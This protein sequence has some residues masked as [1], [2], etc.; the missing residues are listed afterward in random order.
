MNL[1]VTFLVLISLTI[2]SGRQ[3]SFASNDT[4]PGI[5]V[6]LRIE[7]ANY[8]I[9]EGLVLSDNHTISTPSSN[10]TF[11]CDGTNNHTHLNSGPTFTS[12][13]DN[14]S[15]LHNFTWD[16]TYSTEFDDFFITSIGNK[17]QGY[18]G[19]LLNY[20]FIIVGGCQQRVRYMD[21]VLFGIDAFNKVHI[22]MLDGPDTAIVGHSTQLTVRD[23]KTG[24]P[25]AGANVAGQTSDGDGHVRITFDKAGVQKLKAEKSDSL[26][27]NALTIIVY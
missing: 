14:A 13:L 9:Y 12:A 18:W 5:V 7:A 15:K 26:R 21:E 1:I 8:T 20:Q 2:V 27:S 16:A 19:L 24:L 4:T 25:V 11:H 17:T 3:T 10:G 23:G 22:L 6:N